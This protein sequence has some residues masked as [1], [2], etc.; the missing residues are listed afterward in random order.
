MP[1]SDFSQVRPNGR[2]LAQ[3]Y[4]LP[5]KNSEPTA[6]DEGSDCFTK[7]RT[8]DAEETRHLPFRWQPISGFQPLR[9]DQVLQSFND[10]LVQASIN[11]NWPPRWVN[12]GPNSR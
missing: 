6:S 1:G 2:W 11:R 5:V 4:A 7:R 10:S 9:S 3:K 12:Q 8:T